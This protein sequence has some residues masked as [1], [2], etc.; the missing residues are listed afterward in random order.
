MIVAT[1]VSL[2]YPV[3]PKT[4]RVVRNELDRLHDGDLK[5]SADSETKRLCEKLT[6]HV[7]G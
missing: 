6:G 3:T 2:R 7:Y 5:E 4:F 1:V